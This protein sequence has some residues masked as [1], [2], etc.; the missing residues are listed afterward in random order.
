M[1][2]NVSSGR[3]VL[4]DGVRGIACFAIVSDHLY[5]NHLH[6]IRSNGFNS[7]VDYFFVLSGFVLAPAIFSLDVR[8][9]K[10]FLVGRFIRLYPMLI[11]VFFTLALIQWVP[12]ISKNITDLPPTSLLTFLGSILLL[13]IFWGATIPVNIPLWSLSAEWVTN[14]IATILPSKQK[15]SV[16]IAFG[17]IIEI[18]GLLINYRYRFGWGVIYYSIG[19]G[20]AIVGFYLGMILRRDFKSKNHKGSIK[21][22]S[23]ILIILALNFLLLNTSNFFIIFAAPICYY[24]V[25]EVASFNES[26]L[27]SWIRRLFAYFA[28]ISYGVYLWHMVIGSLEIPS[29]L[30]KHSIPD[31]NGIPKNLFIVTFTVLTLVVVTEASIR[32][33]ETPIRRFA[34]AHLQIFQKN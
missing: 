5:F 34:Y 4:L 32:L 22:L 29:F 24:L 18:A 11:P 8:S 23:L 13:Q 33:V 9:R 17:L 16:L 14:L 19:I 21:I 26:N 27:P 2:K 1:G 12:S 3:F 7:F 6:N 10:K 15:F 20:R 30:L 31:L 28:R 25:R